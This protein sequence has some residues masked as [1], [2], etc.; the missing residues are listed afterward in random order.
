MATNHPK[1]RL[2]N[3]RNFMDFN[4]SLPQRAKDVQFDTSTEWN[5][6][7]ICFLVLHHF[8]P[9]SLSSPSF[10]LFS[11]CPPHYRR[12]LQQSYNVIIHAKHPHIKIIVFNTTFIYNKHSNEMVGRESSVGIATRYGLE[13]PGSNPGGGEIFQTCPDRPWSPP[14]LV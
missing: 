7:R 12:Q 8:L 1:T 14:S 5:E 6:S 4:N 9:P 3:P 10:S 2:N 13:G 11:S